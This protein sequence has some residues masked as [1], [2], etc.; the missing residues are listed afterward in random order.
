MIWGS[1]AQDTGSSKTLHRARRA[2][3]S[4]QLPIILSQL[5][6]LEFGFDPDEIKLLKNKMKVY[7]TAE[8]KRKLWELFGL[9]EES[10]QVPDPGPSSSSL[11]NLNLE[12]D[13]DNAEMLLTQVTEVSPP[14]DPT[15]QLSSESK[16]PLSEIDPRTCGVDNPGVAVELMV[17]PQTDEASETKVPAPHDATLHD[18][19]DLDLPQRRTRSS[20]FS[21]TLFRRLAGML[22]R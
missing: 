14:N 19:T 3:T 5:D 12:R 7:S 1:L 6:S 11:S 17:I 13:S 18:D 10:E 2:A 20:L 8:I 9:S 15:E 21:S 16:E 4:P 22:P